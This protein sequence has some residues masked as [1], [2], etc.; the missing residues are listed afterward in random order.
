VVEGLWRRGGAKRSGEMRL[1]IRAK[2]LAGFGIVLLLMSIVGLTGTNR[3]GNG[4]GRF[5]KS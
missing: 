4:R 3:R 1:N 2:L 5:G